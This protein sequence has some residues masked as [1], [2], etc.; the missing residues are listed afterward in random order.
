M[1]QTLHTLGC[2]GRQPRDFVA[3]LRGAGVRTVG[4]VR[5]RPDRASMGSHARAK[6]ADQ[7]IAALLAGGGTRHRA[8]PEPGNPL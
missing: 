4:D 6:R 2:G 7:G 5:L 8:L 3:M 1:E